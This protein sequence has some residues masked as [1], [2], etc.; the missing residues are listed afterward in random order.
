MR[1]L[2]IIAVAVILTVLIP[3]IKFDFAE[4]RLQDLPNWQYLG[5]QDYDGFSLGVGKFTDGN[6]TC[7]LAMGYSKGGI[8]CLQSPSTNP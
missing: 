6:I 7:Y 1:K 8:S 3:K 2:I 5:K 4:S